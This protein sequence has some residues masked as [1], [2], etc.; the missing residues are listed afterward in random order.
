[1]RARQTRDLGARNRVIFSMRSVLWLVGVLLAV[2]M[3][4]LR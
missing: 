4:D 3:P 1:V 2:L